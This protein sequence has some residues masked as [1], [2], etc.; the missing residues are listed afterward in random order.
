MSENNK[1]P[2]T[3][4]Q[5]RMFE[6]YNNRIKK[7]SEVIT[8]ECDHSFSSVVTVFQSIRSQSEGHKK[9]L[10][11]LQLRDWFTNISEFDPS[12]GQVLHSSL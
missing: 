1:I 5:Q 8:E 2:L 9:A 3:P 6:E 7:N 10:L 12:S 4:R 11:L